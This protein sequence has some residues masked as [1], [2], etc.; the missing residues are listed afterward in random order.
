MKQH[1]SANA[2]GRT[3]NGSNNRLLDPTNLFDKLRSSLLIRFKKIFQ[4]IAT[5]PDTDNVFAA[6]LARFQSRLDYREDGRCRTGVIT[7]ALQ[8]ESG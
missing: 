2:N 7:E 3:I 1:G 5:L 4:V 8:S 6:D